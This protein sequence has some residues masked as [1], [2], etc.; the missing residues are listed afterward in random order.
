MNDSQY[1]KVIQA[2]SSDEG[3]KKKMLEIFENA[4]SNFEK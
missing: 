2:C 1:A 3:K 4:Y